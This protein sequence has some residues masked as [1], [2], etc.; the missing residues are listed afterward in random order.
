[1]DEGG[2][3]EE[4]EDEGSDEEGEPSPKHMWC[5][6]QQEEGN[7]KEVCQGEKEGCGRSSWHPCL[8]Y[9]LS[10][11]PFSPKHLQAMRTARV[12]MREQT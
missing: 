3:E 8:H 11:D 9:D 12:L 10:C 6:Q 5:V 1:M 4:E 7:G 2:E